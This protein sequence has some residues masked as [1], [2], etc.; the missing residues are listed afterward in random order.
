MR[1]DIFTYAVRDLQSASTHLRRELVRSATL[2]A[3]LSMACAAGIFLHFLGSALFYSL[4]PIPDPRG[5]YVLRVIGSEQ[6][7][8]M[9]T[10][11]EL[12]ELSRYSRSVTAISGL[13]EVGKV[14]INA[15]GNA[16][17]VN[18][19]V[20]QGDLFS[21]LELRPFLGSLATTS[22]EIVVS[23]QLAQELGLRLT[24]GSPETL[25]LG[26]QSVLVRGILPENFAGVIRGTQTDV[27]L[28]MRA[29]SLLS[30]AGSPVAARAPDQR[31]HVLCRLITGV[32]PLHAQHELL[33]LLTHIP[34]S[35]DL[36]HWHSGHISVALETA[37]YGLRDTVVRQFSLSYSILLNL[38]VSLIL[39]SSVTVAILLT[40]ALA[41][42]KDEFA[43]RLALGSSYGHLM[44]LFIS[45]VVT[46]GICAAVPAG[47][48]ARLG[49]NYLLVPVARSMGV[50]LSSVGFSDVAG[51]DLLIVALLCA[52]SSV[53]PLLWLLGGRLAMGSSLTFT[54]GVRWINHV[55]RYALV[56]QI[57]LSV[58]ISA[59]SFL[60]V[61]SLAHLWYD[62]RGYEL[63][64]IA[65]WEFASA[66]L[67]DDPGRTTANYIALQ[68]QV[69]ALPG[70]IS[71]SLSHVIPIDSAFSLSTRV[72]DIDGTY[73]EHVRV[74][75]NAVGPNFFKTFGI[76]SLAGR[77]FS[78]AD[79]SG[80][81]PVV[82]VSD[83]L[84]RKW[85][86]D[87]PSLALGKRIVCRPG[88]AMTIIGI[89]ADTKYGS[90]RSD[91]GGVLF[92][93]MSQSN[94]VNLLPIELS[95]RY[96]ALSLES[97]RRMVRPLIAD[98]PVSKETT[99]LAE[100][101]ASVSKE[102]LLSWVGSLFTMYAMLLCGIGNFGLVLYDT[103]RRAK[104]IAIR[105]AVGAT[106]VALTRAVVSNELI[107]VCIGCGVGV[108]LFSAA[109]KLME[110]FLYK[111]EG[112]QVVVLC[113]PL[114]I[115]VLSIAGSAAIALSLSVRTK[116]VSDALK[117]L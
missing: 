41:N 5:L 105:L 26:N 100:A 43:T 67:N 93:P 71:V 51:P 81:E 59:S 101:S 91:Q 39:L 86:H 89:V 115:T 111:A 46:L 34:D 23:Y 30:D 36:R 74:R 15:H 27:Y 3:L 78:G 107:S 110:G 102:R 24:Q 60:L 19:V 87:V 1:K 53:P 14:R 37:R 66:S 106:V 79:S 44:S 20:Y 90:L 84:A 69:S 54:S 88:G 49:I 64:R 35:E 77:D 70:V 103:Q 6:S 73:V 4:L 108:G 48:A 28:S 22:N 11:D 98:M 9:F 45:E 104:E 117:A 76:I 56:V 21:T 18:A 31:L 63:D 92:T 12:L 94:L 96:Q 58:A 52:V 114:L 10:A 80:T 8:N 32:S 50:N 47:C 61:Q 17:F 109:R 85:F 113:A 116:N 38:A 68:S 2:V 25:K 72:I 95:A 29:Q 33:S 112:L 55:G 99:L 83:S 57:A 40:V 75:R 82:V 13:S 7:A 65:I 16:Y 62:E 97:L 42:R